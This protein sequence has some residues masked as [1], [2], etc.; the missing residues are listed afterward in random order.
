MVSARFQLKPL[1]SLLLS[2]KRFCILTL[3]RNR[4][5]LFAAADDGISELDLAPGQPPAGD[6]PLGTCFRRVD[7]S[8]CEAL[9]GSSAPLILAGPQHES[10]LYR[11]VNSYPHLLETALNGIV[12]DLTPQELLEQVRPWV[13]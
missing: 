2:N 6:E 13:Q 1:L 12:D 7:R 10:A 3:S 5:R 9:A 4:P 11:K 8:V